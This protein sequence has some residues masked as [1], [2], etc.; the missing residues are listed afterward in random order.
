MVGYFVE[1]MFEIGGFVVYIGVVVYD[2]VVDFM[3]SEVDGIYV[4]FGKRSWVGVL[5]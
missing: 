4:I 2:F 3:G 5:V 1:Y